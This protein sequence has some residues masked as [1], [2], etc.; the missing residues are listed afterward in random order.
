MKTSIVT[1]H[2][3]PRALTTAEKE[4]RQKDLKLQA[5]KDKEMVRGIFHFHEVPGGRMNFCYK[6][7]KGQD[8]EN[9]ELVDG[10]AYTIPLGVARHL[11][12]NGWY[13]VHT[14][15]VDD[16]GRPVA[17][18]G[19]KVRRFGFASLEFVDIDDLSGDNNS[20]VTVEKVPQL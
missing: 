15:Q 14:Y 12:R 1:N 10:Q 13:P 11:N 6:A 5:E 7:Y 17:R 16:S 20:L 9:Y 18:I 19:Q 2:E 3:Q 8:V 4:K